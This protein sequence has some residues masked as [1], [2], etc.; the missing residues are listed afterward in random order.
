MAQIGEIKTLSMNI[1]CYWRKNYLVMMIVERQT[2]TNCIVV[3]VLLFPDAA[4]P[5][6]C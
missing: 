1:H 6:K 5:G 2:I 3:Y 4:E